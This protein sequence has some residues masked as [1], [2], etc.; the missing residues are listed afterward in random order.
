MG[1]EQTRGIMDEYLAALQG[2]GDFGRYFTED[3][4]WTTVETGDELRGREVV[5][6]YIVALHTQALDAHPEVKNLVVGE[7]GAFLE[8]DL[9]GTHTGDFAGIP[10]TG[11]EL[12]VPY[13]VAYD[14][15]PDGITALRAYIPVTQ[16]VNRLKEAQTALASASG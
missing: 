5:R 7:D 2:G 16:M 15:S 14:L 4:R 9:V 6:D 8:A 10:A 12:R 11:A 3:V 1:A 13:A